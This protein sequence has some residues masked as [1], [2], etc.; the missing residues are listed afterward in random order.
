M[1]CMID[2]KKTELFAFDGESIKVDEGVVGLVTLLTNHRISAR[3]CCEG[4][5]LLIDQTHYEARNHRCEIRMVHDDISLA[6]I[7]GLLVDSQFFDN[8][9]AFWKI[10]FNTVPAG[11]YKGEH[12]ITIHFP[13]QDLQPLIDYIKIKEELAAIDSVDYGSIFTD[14]Q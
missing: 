7:Q 3:S 13:P 8:D 1:V 5:V 11:P 4:V 12:R 14:P 6:F 2:H 9:K 10:E